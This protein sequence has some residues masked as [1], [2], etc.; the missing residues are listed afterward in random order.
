MDDQIWSVGLVVDNAEARWLSEDSAAQYIL[1]AAEGHFLQFS[2]PPSDQDEEF[3]NFRLDIKAGSAALA[4]DRALGIVYRARRAAKLPD[5]VVPVA[6]VALSADFESGE[7]FLDQ[8]IDLA[9]NEQ[10]SMAI[11]AAEIFLESQ[12]MQMTELALRRGSPGAKSQTP[13]LHRST[14]QADTI[15]RLLDLD[16]MQLPE[17]EEYR[18]HRVRR[19]EIAHRGRSFGED[20][21][22]SSIRTVRAIWLELTSA[23]RRSEE[24]RAAA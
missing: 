2:S 16:V 11:V 20:E 3:E 10:F 1:D 4:E 13:N 7:H 12:I 15:K 22:L 8:A 17:W 19:N 9:E 6:W 18:A 23:A 21:A 5:R 24:A 14:E